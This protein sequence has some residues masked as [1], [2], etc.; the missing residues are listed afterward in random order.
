MSLSTSKSCAQKV[1]YKDLFQLLEAKKYDQAEPFLRTF[2]ADPKNVGHPNAH[3]QMGKIYQDKSRGSDPIKYTEITRSYADSAIIHYKKA[4]S[5]LDEKEVRKN[6]EYYQAYL[7]RDLRTGKI[8]IKVSDITFD[9][10][11]KVEVL[12]DRKVKLV[13]A[14]SLFS[15]ADS[16]YSRA[17]ASFIQLR[18]TFS[19]IDLLLLHADDSILN[20]LDRLGQEHRNATGS[21]S[22]FQKV[23]K[24][25]IPQQSQKVFEEVDISDFSEEGIEK[26]SFYDNQVKVWKYSHW[27][28]EIGKTIR[29]QV[30]PAKAILINYHHRIGDLANKTRTDSILFAHEIKRLEEELT[31][32]AILRYDSASLPIRIMNYRLAEIIYYG[33]YLENERIRDS[34]N[35][36]LQVNMAKEDLLAVQRMD[37]LIATIKSAGMAEPNAYR[38]FMKEAYGSSQDWRSW[39]A[40]K[41][42]LIGS[43]MERHLADLDRREMESQW[44]IHENDSIPLFLGEEWSLDS[45][46]VYHPLL[47]ED[48]FYTSGLVVID[49]APAK[50]YFSFINV[51]RRPPNVAY[52]EVSDSL[53]VQTTKMVPV[54]EK[55]SLG[56]YLLISYPKTQDTKWTGLFTKF[57]EEGSLLWR[58]EM[59]LEGE[60]DTLMVSSKGKE[61]TVTYK[62]NSEEGDPKLLTIDLSTDLQN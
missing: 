29:D 3:L 18:E 24:G 47:L 22:K 41:N 58:K 15:E 31:R 9:L 53:D 12:E 34:L 46:S 60:P 39:I 30:A 51:S 59:A 44:M 10:E 16:M 61:V 37:S 38:T 20:I 11:K 35:V 42:N 33:T 1:K 48:E 14:K 57:S 23:S 8:G 50:G 52:F 26:S 28:D 21:L 54:F 7:R 2:L 36:V 55:D 27:S 5:L 13:E 4:R 19:D 40:E 6:D 49:G 32:S 43:L 17:N 56:C 25:L 62:V 45:G